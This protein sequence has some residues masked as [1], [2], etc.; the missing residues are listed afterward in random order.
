MRK[1]ICIVLAVLLVAVLPAAGESGVRLDLPEDL[2][3][4]FEYVNQ[5][6]SSVSIDGGFNSWDGQGRPMENIDGVWTYSMDVTPATSITFKY[7]VDGEYLQDM[8][9]LAPATTEDGFGGRNGVVNVAE[10][11]AGGS[12]AF[13]TRVTFGTVTQLYSETEFLTRDLGG[14]G[15]FGYEPTGSEL[16]G[17]S[18]WKL[19]ADILPGVDT[20]VE[21]KVYDGGITLYKQAADASIDE[22]VT[23]EVSF[24]DG[25][26]NLGSALF[27]PFNAMNG[28]NNPELAHFKAGLETPFVRLSTGYAN[29]KSDRSSQEFFFKTFDN[30]RSANDGFL[31]ISNASELQSIGDLLDFDVMVGLTKRSGGH[32]VYSWA[33]LDMGD[34]G[35]YL[36][37]NTIANREDGLRYYGFD[38]IHS[39]GLGL[40]ASLLDGMF[41]A[42]LQAL[43]SYDVAVDFDA[44][45]ALAVGTRMNF[46]HDAIGLTVGLDARYL[47]S[48]FDMIHANAPDDMG[49]ILLSLSPAVQPVDLLKL[50]LNYD[51]KVSND[52]EGKT[53]NSFNPWLEL[54]LAGLIGIDT[55]VNSFGKMAMDG[56]D[57]VFDEA[58]GSVTVKDIA[59]LSEAAAGYT[60][61]HEGEDTAFARVAMSDLTANVSSLRLGYRY[62]ADAPDEGSVYLGTSLTGLA[63]F[64]PE[65]KLDAGWHKENVTLAARA[66]LLENIHANTALIYRLAE[67][68][69]VPAGAAL[70]GALGASIVLPEGW[71]D[72]IAF[73]QYSYDFNPYSGV[74]DTERSTISFADDF[75][76]HTGGNGT[77][78][79]RLG[80]GWNF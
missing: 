1:N 20:F 33:D 8:G 5:D 6:A 41:S 14:E 3:L 50:G 26:E 11:G 38:G 19:T 68:G 2:V 59:V 79:L 58:G 17:K 7:I 30:E 10:L 29:A 34:Y 43:M 63:A 69:D 32:G 24:A 12:D 70:G 60:Y 73:L 51:F 39:G 40:R 25:M 42:R 48:D 31:E 53:L 22:D 65:L 13:R 52:L 54:Y 16:K 21:I 27:A 72:G 75:I 76:E 80:I 9:G 57:F 4:V 35:A 66:D 36:V 67:H 78:M 55:T 46:S 18:Y 71:R 62:A 77:S 15:L 61:A 47:G 74:G 23:P 44:A 28:G 37:Y 49:N 45:Q 56:G 64:M